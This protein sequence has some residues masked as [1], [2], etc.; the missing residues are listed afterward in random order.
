M[1][2]KNVKKRKLL[3]LFLWGLFIF[4]FGWSIYKNFTAVNT[5]TVETKQVVEQKLI[6][7]NAIESFFSSFVD[8]F[9][10]IENDDKP[11]SSRKSEL[12]QYMPESLVNLN[13]QIFQNDLPYKAKLTDYKLWKLEQLSD[14]S[15]W[16]ITYSVRQ[17][18]NRTQI[19]IKKT[20]VTVNEAGK[21]VKKEV[22]KPSQKQVYEI[23]DN[24]FSSVIHIDK[25]GNMVVVQSPTIASVPSKSDY[26][27]PD[28][29]TDSSVSS[30]DTI[31]I[32][33]FLEN[34]FDLYPTADENTLQYYSSSG[35]LP[36]INKDYTFVELTKFICKKEDNKMKAYVT[37]KFFDESL[38]MYMYS[39]YNFTL[40]KDSKWIIVENSPVY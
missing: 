12:L 14:K 21:K 9:Y 19:E 40:K 32:K 39:Q 35:I 15:N 30:D 2:I 29:T 34:F 26:I 5:Y 11:L 37:V 33:K 25:K 20:T 36:V 18:V 6:D 8:V 4:A 23:V 38:G 27:V 13:E 31:E 17:S 1:K 10:N 16:K 28:I 7:T 24:C 3:L 22:E